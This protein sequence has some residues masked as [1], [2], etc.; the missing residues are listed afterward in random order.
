M[1]D[2]LAY[3]NPNE[4]PHDV[5]VEWSQFDPN[6]NLRLVQRPDAFVENIPQDVLD[7]YKWSND[8]YE[9]A[10]PR[11]DEGKQSHL[12]TYFANGVNHKKYS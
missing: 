10:E 4:G 12:R 1:F 2:V 3:R 5:P 6:T 11:T 8:F 7:D 9:I